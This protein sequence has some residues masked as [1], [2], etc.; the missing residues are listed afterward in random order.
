MSQNQHD[1]KSRPTKETS[2]HPPRNPA[3]QTP[4]QP[5]VPT[6]HSPQ[7]ET[8]PKNRT[9]NQHSKSNKNKGRGRTSPV[10]PSFGSMPHS[11]GL[12]VQE[13][14]ELT[15]IRLAREA[16]TTYSPETS[17]YSDARTHTTSATFRSGYTAGE[18]D[19]Y[20]V[21]SNRSASTSPI[22]NTD[23]DSF[24]D[25]YSRYSYHPPVALSPSSLNR[26]ERDR[27]V[28]YSPE[29]VM[30]SMK[31]PPHTSPNHLAQ[32]H[33]QSANNIPQKS[34]HG[35]H[36]GLQKSSPQALIAQI[37]PD[38][39]M[40]TS[41]PIPRIDQVNHFSESTGPAS[42]TVNLQPP[43]RSIAQVTERESSST[44]GGN[45]LRKFVSSSPL[46]SH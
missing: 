23:S 1:P 32:S 24:D 31:S 9:D 6:Y 42:L 12:T 46:T 4:R 28:P 33:L 15:R 21:Y 39:Q 18:M 5:V 22:S 35:I 11:H 27:Q 45:S 7:L 2:G 16:G 25:S 44:A 13:L 19:S 34:F 43:P 20:S 8:K 29:N 10:D 41:A 14:K 3:N 40:A 37:V 30:I 36:P 38:Y 17:D 26:S